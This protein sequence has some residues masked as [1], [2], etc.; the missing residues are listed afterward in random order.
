[1]IA[2]TT[3]NSI[4]V[5]AGRRGQAAFVGV[6]HPG[7]VFLA[8][9]IYFR[10]EGTDGEGLSKNFARLIDEDSL[11]RARLL[12]NLFRLA[13]IL[14]AAMPAMLP[15][16]QLTLTEGKTLTLRFPKKLR[17]LVGE[18]VEK[19]LTALADELGRTGRIVVD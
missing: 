13:Y 8:L 14:S 18:R 19:R 1:M 16:L 11:V 2:M 9:C 5:N 4:R 6:D 3:N 17:D 15:R 7:R 12:S 10:Y